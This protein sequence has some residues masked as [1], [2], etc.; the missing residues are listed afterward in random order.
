[1][2]L[3]E[4]FSLEELT[5][6]EVAARAGIDNTPSAEVMRNLLRLAEGLELVRA[7]LGNNPIHV[8]SGY[9]SPR[10][11]QMVGGSKNSMHTLGLAADILCPVFGTPL[12]VCRAIATSGIPADQIIHEFGHWCHVG[13]APDGGAARNELLT[14]ANVATGYELGLR[15]V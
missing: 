15:N 6:S 10:L 9:R 14:I 7:A 2:M 4:H 8:T 11:N 5:A 12:E 3:S 1:M 13:F